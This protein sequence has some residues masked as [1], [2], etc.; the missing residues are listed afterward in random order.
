MRHWRKWASLESNIR[1]L[2][3]DQ[4]AKSFT[5]EELTTWA[6]WGLEDLVRIRPRK[7]SQEYPSTETTVRLPDDCYKPYLVLFP[8]GKYIEEFEPRPG[9]KLYSEGSITTSSY[10]NSWRYDD[11]YLYL[12]RAPGDTWTLFYAAYY[13]RI[14]GAEDLLRWPRWFFEAV[15]LYAASKALEVKAVQEA[16]INRW[17][18]RN[19]Q[20]KPTDNPMAIEAD[21]MMRLYYNHVNTWSNEDKVVPIWHT[22]SRK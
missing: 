7:A 8:D 5:S 21:R 11:E 14:E 17:N 2:I 3:G 18:T 13:S 19:D 12:Y 4:S 9:D 10:P 15:N 20:G 1:T 16:S 6:N 22:G